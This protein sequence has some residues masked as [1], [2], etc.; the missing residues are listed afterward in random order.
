MTRKQL[1][2]RLPIGNLSHVCFVKRLLAIS[3]LVI[4]YLI[5]AKLGLALAFV[6][7]S[8]TAVWPPTGIALAALILFGS[9]LWPAIFLGAFFANIMTAGSVWTSLGIAT[10]NTLEAVLGA[11]LV[12]RFAGGRHA[13]DRP[14][15][16]LKF[17][18]LAGLGSTSIS[19]TIGVT[20]LNLG[21]HVSASQYARVWCT[22][23]LGDM[24]G[25]LIL[26][27]LLILWLEN[28]RFIENER[29]LAECLLVFVLLAVV[30]Y[31]AFARFPAFTTISIAFFS[32][33]VL[34]WTAVRLGRRVASVAVFLICAIAVWATQNGYGPFVL[35]DR[36]ESLLLL[37][38]F[39]GMIAVMIMM[40][41]AAVFSRDRT[42]QAL[43]DSE[44]TV[45][46]H[47]AELETIYRTAPVGLGFTDRNLRFV[48]VNE[49]L[50]EIDGITASDH[51]AR[52]LREILPAALAD[53]LEPLY[54]RV[55]NT[56]EPV[57][58]LEVQ[59]ETKA[60][61]GVSRVWS[62]NYHPVRGDDGIMGVS[63]M[64][65]EITERKQAEDALREADRRKD[66][67]LA[68]L[69]HELRNPLGV[70]STS[71]HLL[72]LKG[73]A[74][75]FFVEVRQ[76]IERQTE[77]MSQMMNDLLDV[78]RITRGQIRL[79]KELCDLVDIV[80][81]TAEDHRSAMDAGGLQFFAHLPDSPLWLLGDCTRLAQ[82]VGNLL[83][84]A[85][86]FTDQGGTVSLGLV[87]APGPIALL[88]LQDTGIGIEPEIL[89]RIFEPFTQ[90]DHSIDRSRGG[91]GLGLALV[92]GLVE[93]HGGDVLAESAGRGCGSEFTV[94]LPLIGNYTSP[95]PNLNALEKPST[96]SRRILIIED[97]TAA[98]RTMQM[99][100]ELTGHTVKIANTGPQGIEAAEQFHPGIVLCDIGLPGLDGYAVA[101]Q[102]RKQTELKGMY[103]IA[104]SGY[105][106]QADQQRAHD[107][108][109][110]LHMTKPINADHLNEILRALPR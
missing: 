87:E 79:K 98:A 62:V 45:R 5:S 35:A 21:G 109:F 7:P 95:E 48:S 104:I 103:L 41:S 77:H 110:D 29:K 13:F 17:A 30:G 6:H 12:N 69:G 25:A 84:N 46:R 32:I 38:E 40:L 39:G 107:A 19:A 108:G 80:R 34:L 68:M 22:W 54:R 33:P 93:L 31:L 71:V 1:L 66:E 8:A 97:N 52:N 23:W 10:G 100:L 56:G 55:I 27:P 42:E 74:D 63:V 67:F 105:G 14:Q 94:R 91:L 16:V 92:K 85:K 78:S 99:L 82:V 53:T 106:Q 28:P 81:H 2:A 44:K 89:E 76:T 90:S 88:S 96:P 57:V 61:P 102:L 15:D 75:P 60:K 47:L 73:P 18:A 49:T 59:G 11:Y 65:Q 70:I 83:Y 51:T 72:R 101:R 36:N 3:L 37:Q 86:K 24:G 4:V 50:A 43:R 20:T 26:A 58:N 9:Q 64:V